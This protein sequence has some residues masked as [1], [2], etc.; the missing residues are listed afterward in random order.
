MSCDTRDNAAAWR[1]AV[2]EVM[3]RTNTFWPPPSDDW[4]KGFILG[5]GY[6]QGQ[7]SDVRNRER[8]ELEDMRA[9]LEGLEK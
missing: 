1:V 4:M 2:L 8:K 7:I 9:R 3:A 6:E 5:R